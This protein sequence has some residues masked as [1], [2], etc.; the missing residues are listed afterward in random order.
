MARRAAIGAIAGPKYRY[1]LETLAREIST[2][3][4]K[5]GQKLPSEAALVRQFATSRITVGRAVRELKQRGLVDR[6]AGSGTYVRP[7]PRDGRGALLGLLI[8][9]LGTTDI[10]EPI[11]Q[12]M[13][14][15]PEAG[16]HALLWGRAES[17]RASKEAQALELCAQ[18]IEQNAA[19]VFFAPLELTPNKDD[20]NERILGA[21]DGAHIPVVLL[22]RDIVPFPGR[23][24]HDLVA[25]DNHRAGYIITEHLLHVGCRRP[26]FVS[27]PNGAAT[28]DARIAGFRDALVAHRLD[29][30]PESIQLLPAVGDAEIKTMMQR[31]RPDGLVCVNDRL[32][33]QVMQSLLTLGHEVPEEVRIVGIDDVGYAKLLPVPLTTVHQPCRDIGEAAIKAML[34]RIADPTRITR[35]I[36]LDCKVV[37]RESCGA[38]V[39]AA[40]HSAPTGTSG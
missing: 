34:E 37:V 7:Q 16:R 27:Y 38:R 5:A 22:D 2:G 13:A 39:I 18:Y 33:G 9:D 17:T 8:P 21:L 23:T 32:A 20:T 10:F 12:G 28:V 25:I 3:K 1:V 4:Y 26:V 14:G 24:K 35:D 31:S 15:A 30:A 6:I 19:G 40:S 36:L 29:P 11:C